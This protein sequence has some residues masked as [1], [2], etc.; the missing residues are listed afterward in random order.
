[1]ERTCAHIHTHTY[2]CNDLLAIE[3]PGV[4]R[5]KSALEWRDCSLRSG[6]QYLPVGRKFTNVAINASGC[7]L[8]DRDISRRNRT[9]CAAVRE[10]RRWPWW[11]K[12]RPTTT[13]ACMNKFMVEEL[14]GRRR[15]TGA[16]GGNA[17]RTP[18]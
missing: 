2:T 18:D 15:R 12:V 8:Q 6:A 11:N 9:F 17:R 10:V 16:G 3:F 5:K 13:T 4:Q 1:M 7:Q 14:A